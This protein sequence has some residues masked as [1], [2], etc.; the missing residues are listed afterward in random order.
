MR[1]SAP[2]NGMPPVKGEG[3]LG[4]Q[5]RAWC[6]VIFAVLGRIWLRCVAFGCWCGR[7]VWMLLAACGRYLLEG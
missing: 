2:P 5:G 1:I 7:V 3:R 6:F 4:A